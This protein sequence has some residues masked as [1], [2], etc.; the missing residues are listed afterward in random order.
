MFQKHDVVVD[1][2]RQRAGEVMAV[3]NRIG[4]GPTLILRPPRG[5]VEW[6]VLAENCRHA[7]PHELISAR[8]LKQVERP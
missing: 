5:G 1:D 4:R 8:S 6:E 3:A 2:V 7:E